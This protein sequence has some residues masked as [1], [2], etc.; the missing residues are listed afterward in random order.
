MSE[1]HFFHVF[2]TFDAGGLEVRAVQ[3]MEALGRGVRHS[4]V[5]LDGRTGALSKISASVRIELVQGPR[6][7]HPLGMALTMADAMKV[8]QPHLVLTYNW[9]A[10][11]S[12]AAARLVR[13]D[14]IVHHEDGFGPEESAAVLTRRVYLRRCLLPAVRAV[15]VP[16]RRLEKMALEV[17]RQPAPRVHYLPNGVDLR[18]FHVRTFPEGAAD[19]DVVIGHVGRFRPEK[20]QRALVRAFAVDP[21]LRARARLLFV[22]DGPE[23]EA[24]RALAAELGV[25][26]RV[27]FAGVHRDPAPLYR[28]MDIFALCSTTEQMPLS[29]LEAMATGLPV[30]STRVGDV[31]DMIGEPNKP[32]VVPL[33]QEGGLAE[34]LSVLVADRA[35]RRSVGAANRAL[36]EQAFPLDE[37][38]AKRIDLYLHSARSSG[39]V[40]AAPHP[41]HTL[42]G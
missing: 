3:L 6:A 4:V 33:E 8:R 25:A 19:G 16:S 39:R 40:D 31:A 38:L 5:A 27:T 10:I 20:N 26:D 22:G 36:V 18:H 37:S 15:V 23:L 32:F 29:V 30:V 35:L 17:W 24:T 7:R 2:P 12:I 1:L 13:I 42:G 9:G 34:A 41:L 14:N 21:A 11:E 28:Q